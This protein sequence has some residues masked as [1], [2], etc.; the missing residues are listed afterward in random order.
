VTH[1]VV[2]VWGNCQAGPLGDLLTA[3]LR[4]HGL[5][6]VAIPPVFEIDPAGLGRVR[7][8]L[9]RAAVL[10]THPVR[11]EYR[12]PGCGSE[13]LAALLPPGGRTV[14]VSSIYHA[15]PFPYLVNGHDAQGGRVDAPLTGYHDLQLLAGCLG[16]PVP[17]ANTA[18]LEAVNATSLAELAR[19]DQGLDVPVA[20]L[21]A[22]PDSL[23]TFNHP[24]NPTLA[25]VA[26]A[27]LGVLGVP[28]PVEIPER[29]YLGATRAPIAPTVAAALGW[30]PRPHWVLGGREVGLGEVA[31]AHRAFYARRPDVLHETWERSAP[32]RALLGL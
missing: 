10:V 6:V 20:D 4:R 3:P 2:V 11:D 19:R 8:L 30:Q 9:A 15:G 24:A 22:A 18:Q 12:V 28:G 14:R 23:Y 25:S 5:A 31:A 16:H 1:D 27:V 13:Q 29:P 26:R 21:V 17:V 32:R 7:N